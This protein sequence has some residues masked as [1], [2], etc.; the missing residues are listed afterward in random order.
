MIYLKTA[1]EIELMRQA[2]QIVSKTLGLVAAEIKEGVT[3]KHLDKIAEEFIRDS[4]GVPVFKGY[5]GFPATLCLSMNEQV[6]HGIPSDKILTSGDIISVDCGVKKQGFVGDHAY[7]FCCGEIKQEV[8][9][10][11][12][13][14]KE[15]LY[16]GI[17]QVKSGN[18]IGD[19]SFAIQQHAEKH[20]Y[21]VVRE[22]VGHGLGKSLHEKPEV[23]NYGKRGSGAK[24][25]N[26]L[27]I[28]IE[29]MINMGTKDV[30]QLNDGWTII[31]KDKKP[32]AHFEHDVA[33]VDGKADILSTFVFAEEA[34]KKNDF[35]VNI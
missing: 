8:Q 9:D 20:G 1:E 23:P 28:A 12:R 25:Q 35:L 17:E 11:V 29:P 16:V 14:T 33:V 34:M 27:T 2:A 6:V 26:G 31:T 30:K 13:I 4:G 22:L 15:S 3:L 32:S 10:L 21:G 18:R 5:N 7:T 19:V 24:I